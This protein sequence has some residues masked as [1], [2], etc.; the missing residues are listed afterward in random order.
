V[1]YV[2]DMAPDRLIIGGDFNTPPDRG[3]F[4]PLA[5]FADQASV[6]SG[7][8]AINEFPMARIDQVWSRGIRSVRS[9]AIR[10]VNSD[11]RKVEVW[12]QPSN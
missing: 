7:Y 2:E 3:T 1:E 6:D 8:T 4:A 9:R 10:T 5:E 11:H 12:F